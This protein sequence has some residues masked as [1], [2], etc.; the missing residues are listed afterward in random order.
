MTFD[1]MSGSRYALKKVSLK[2]KEQVFSPFKRQ[3]RAGGDVCFAIKHDLWGELGEP[4]PLFFSSH[5]FLSYFG[6]CICIEEAKRRRLNGQGE[7]YVFRKS[8]CEKTH[9]KNGKNHWWKGT[10]GHVLLFSFPI[11]EKSSLF[12]YICYYHVK[13]LIWMSCQQIWGSEW[14]CP[15]MDD[16]GIRSIPLRL[17]E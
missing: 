16:I 5:A 14:L 2:E 13:L 7:F 3:R 17:Y 15:F 8:S 12:F 10:N 1:R 4:W 11:Q 9:E 6:S